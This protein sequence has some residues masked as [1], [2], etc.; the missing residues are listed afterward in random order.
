M[1]CHLG[2]GVAWAGFGGGA[3]GLEVIE[4]NAEEK[5]AIFVNG[6]TNPV[7]GLGFLLHYEKD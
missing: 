2:P 1:I 7:R 3:D 4:G 6:P 5:G